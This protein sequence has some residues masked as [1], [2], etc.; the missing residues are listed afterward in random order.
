MGPKPPTT[1]CPPCELLECMRC[2]KRIA[3]DPN[4]PCSCEKCVSG[5]HEGPKG[6][7][8]FRVVHPLP[9]TCPAP[10]QGFLPV[11]GYEA[12]ECG[13]ICCKST[14]ITTTTP[15][16]TTPPAPSTTTKPWCVYEGENKEMPFNC[17]VHQCGEYSKLNNSHVQMAGKA[18]CSCEPKQC[19][20]VNGEKVN[21]PYECPKATCPKGHLLEVY[22][23][24]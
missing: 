7:P 14:P 13:D 4:V 5:C 3:A 20:D 23:N 11:P 6:T 18:C 9:Y 10:E 15:P 1:T 24:P 16:T 19:I 17:K 8:G 12:K 22:S 21:M 2:E